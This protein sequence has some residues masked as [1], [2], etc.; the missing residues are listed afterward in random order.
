MPT[1]P[2]SRRERE[3]MEVLYGAEGLTAAEVR[4]RMADPP[5]YSAVRALLRILE[6]KGHIT[7][8]ERGP[9]YVFSPVVSRTKARRSALKSLVQTFFGGSPEQAM[10]ALIDESR[11]KLSAAELDRLA[12][13]I[14]DARKEGR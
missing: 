13:L 14:A 2:L 9:R 3:I 5:G 8:E 7:H 1:P 12:A 10:A 4:E 11:S 6:E